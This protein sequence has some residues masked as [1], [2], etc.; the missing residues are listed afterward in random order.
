MMAAQ[1]VT[2]DII[3]IHV[4]KVFHFK[5]LK[6]KQEKHA[7]FLQFARVNFV[8]YSN[9]FLLKYRIAVKGTM[10]RSKPFKFVNT[11]H[12]Y[13]HVIADVVQCLEYNYSTFVLSR[14]PSCFIGLP[15]HVVLSTLRAC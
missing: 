7:L 13:R 6:I 1:W 15:G 9:M 8:S 12:H 2:E 5:L 11:L 4:K 10:R 14:P 3:Y